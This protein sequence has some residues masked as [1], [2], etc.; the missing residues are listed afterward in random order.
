MAVETMEEPVSPGFSVGMSPEPSTI[1]ESFS[2]PSNAFTPEFAPVQTFAHWNSQPQI[3][4]DTA[5][6]QGLDLFRDT[7]PLHSFP[8]VEFFADL[9][10]PEAIGNMAVS[11]LPF[12]NAEPAY[13]PV[14]FKSSQESPVSTESNLAPESEP[15]IERDGAVEQNTKA[16]QQIANVYAGI[17]YNDALQAYE[18]MKNAGF[19]AEQAAE[20][21]GNLL[22]EG[23]VREGFISPKIIEQEAQVEQLLDDDNAPVGTEQIVDETVQEETP[24]FTEDVPTNFIRDETTNAIRHDTL[25]A[26]WEQSNT[27]AQMAN[28]LPPATENPP[29]LSS[30]IVKDKDGDP[31][32]TDWSYYHLRDELHNIGTVPSTEAGAVTVFSGLVNG[33][34]AVKVGVLPEARQATDEEVE[35]V[36]TPAIH[37]LLF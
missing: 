18:Y 34:T 1:P 2:F 7:A 16:E 37:S 29:E 31:V 15:A 28:Q 19:D 17:Q 9:E 26:A 33:N 12:A 20:R 13:E 10:Y 30:G 4:N 11:T 6:P 35:K 27:G 23:A 22:V 32:Q 14:T 21:L 36:V 8:Q 25:I 5:A 24:D 3:F